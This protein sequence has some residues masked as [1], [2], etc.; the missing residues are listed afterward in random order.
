M[1]TNITCS[2]KLI[3][4]LVE[5]VFA[6]CC[7]ALYIFGSQLFETRRQILPPGYGP[8]MKIVPWIIAKIWSVCVFISLKYKNSL[9]SRTTTVQMSAGGP[10]TT[11]W[12]PQQSIR[13]SIN[14]FTL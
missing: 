11:G 4:C 6:L 13:N 1:E 2:N 5:I 12:E 7:S 10:R 9:C 8:P 14:Q 3:D